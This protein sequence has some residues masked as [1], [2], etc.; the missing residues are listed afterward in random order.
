MKLPLF[1]R[2]FL[3]DWVETAIGLFLGL[4]L[5]LPTDA[6]QVHQATIIVVSA[7]L[8][9]LVSAV[10]RALPGFLTWFAEKLGVPPNS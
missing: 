8:S 7:V 9:A 6:T 4:N 3:L 2:K 10:R 5:V 1:A